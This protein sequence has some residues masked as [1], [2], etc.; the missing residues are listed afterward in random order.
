[1][2]VLVVGARGIIHHKNGDIQRFSISSKGIRY[3][4]RRK[5]E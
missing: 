4:K 3:Y 2:K 5:E 1:M